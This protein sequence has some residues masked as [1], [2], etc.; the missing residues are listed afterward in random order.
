MIVYYSGLPLNTGLNLSLGQVVMSNH[1]CF[2]S[3]LCCV[4]IAHE[5]TTKFR[6]FSKLSGFAARSL[7]QYKCLFLHCISDGLIC[8]LV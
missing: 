5:I 4:C 8:F 3:K 1:Q 7:V 2:L 6:L